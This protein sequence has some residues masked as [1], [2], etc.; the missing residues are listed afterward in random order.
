MTAMSEAV[1]SLSTEKCGSALIFAAQC[2]KQCL[3]CKWTSADGGLNLCSAVVEAMSCLSLEK[4][5]RWRSVDGGLNLCRPAFEAV[6]CLSILLSSS[7]HLYLFQT[8]NRNSLVSISFL[9]DME[10]S[11]NLC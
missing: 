9:E 8:M 11:Q 7:R 2:L 10:Q 6:S 5:C 3:A 4:C 1:P